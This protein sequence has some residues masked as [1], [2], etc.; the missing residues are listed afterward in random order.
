MAAPRK[1]PPKDALADIER[2]A[3][4][5]HSTVGLAKHFGV[6]RSVVMRW[7]EEDERFEETYEQGRDSYR[8]A[9][10]EQIVSM[11][12][13]GKNPAGFIYL[14]KAKYKMYDQASSNTKVDVAVNAPQAVMIVT[15]HGTDEEWAAK[16]AEQQRKLTQGDVQASFLRLSAP[17]GASET[18]AEPVSYPQPVCRHMTPSA[19]IQAPSWRGRG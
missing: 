7:F 2:L 19:P 18:S 14:L 4:K 9:L 11:T 1:N 8:Q 6:A 15:D 3:G 10:E 12:L 17:Q 16:V 5:G 13:A